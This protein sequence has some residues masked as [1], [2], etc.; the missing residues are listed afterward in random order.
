MYDF[1]GIDE[2]PEAINLAFSLSWNTEN[3]LKNNHITQHEVVRKIQDVE[4]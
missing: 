2:I 3:P 1:E 4:G